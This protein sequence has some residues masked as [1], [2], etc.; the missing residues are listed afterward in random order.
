MA[1]ASTLSLRLAENLNSA[2]K[3]STLA[4]LFPGQ[5][6]QQVGAGQDLFQT[7]PAARAVFEK[8][9]SILG[10]PLSKMCFHGPE[11]EL[12][13][14]VN[15][16]PAI[17]VT[18]LAC[19]AAALDS[20]ALRRRPALLAG[21]SLGEYTALVAAGALDFQ[22]AL[23][24]VRRR[25]ELMQEAGQREPGLM[26]ALVGL[27]EGK[28]E[29]VCRRAGAEPCNYNAPGQTVIGGT[30]QAVQRA[31][32]LAEELGGRA[33][34]LSVSVAAH[35]SLMRSAA[36]EFAT[37]V[38]ACPLRDPALP[39]VANATADVLITAEA[40]RSELKQQMLR[41]VLWRQSLARM[42]KAGIT[43]FVEIGPGHVLSSLL[44]RAEPGLKAIS[45]SDVPSLDGLR[46]V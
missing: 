36:E 40:V 23:S 11:P 12:L 30:P 32:A 43:T 25:A 21:H 20:G 46:D 10:F 45:V 27:D 9:D 37:V 35:T 8:A 6:S 26:A 3:D 38:D 15:A 44:K 41:P 17:L 14:T 39:V 33:L 24:L 13:Q 28:V 5:G 42:V 31:A 16:Q 18:S 22:A 19:L 4:L 7:A 2:A 1:S 34:P 29:E